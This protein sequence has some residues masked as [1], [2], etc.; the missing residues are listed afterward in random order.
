MRPVKQFYSIGRKQLELL[1]RYWT[2]AVHCFV[3]YLL[4]VIRLEPFNTFPVSRQRKALHHPHVL[5]AE[6][7]MD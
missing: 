3:G 6:K 4:V 5:N 2:A 1:T 7:T